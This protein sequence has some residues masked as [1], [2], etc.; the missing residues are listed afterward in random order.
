MMPEVIP[1][2]LNLA[3]GFPLM[4][5]AILLLCIDCGTELAP[6]ISL[7]Y[8]KPEADVMSRP[9]RNAKT[10]HLVT[11]KTVF[12][13]YCMA[14][15]WEFL[16]SMLAFFLVM[17]HYCIH[18]SDIPWNG[19]HYFSSDSDNFTTTCGDTYIASRQVDILAQAQ[20]AYWV[21][22]CGSQF[23]H[24]FMCKT[25]VESV[26]THGLF[27]NVNMDYG[28]AAPHYCHILHAAALLFIP[29][30]LNHDVLCAFF[31]GV[32]I[33]LGVILIIVFVPAHSFF[34]SQIFPGVYWLIVFVGWAGL[35]LLNEPRKY[36][37][38]KYKGQNRFVDFLAW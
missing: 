22:L 36:L 20:T 30:N 9:P 35:F 34:Q 29:S 11:L 8:E 10:D 6:A 13:W 19:D 24:I 5:N 7:A 37:I 28:N 31:A 4:V 16:S 21:V 25:R 23:F 3:F 32:L 1:V 2:L 26:F 17:E 27:D 18:P 38:R 12:Y 15:L 33:E 14:G